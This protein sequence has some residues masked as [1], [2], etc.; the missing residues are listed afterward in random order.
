MA[1]LTYSKTEIE[2]EHDYAMPHVECGLKLHGGFS[3]DGLYLSP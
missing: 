3:E 1:R 2:T